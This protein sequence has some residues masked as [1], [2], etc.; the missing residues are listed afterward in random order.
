MHKFFADWVH[1]YLRVFQIINRQQKRFFLKFF[2]VSIFYLVLS[3]INALTPYLLGKANESLNSPQ[4]GLSPMF[5]VLGFGCVWTVSKLTVLLKGVMS[6]PI[7]VR[8]DAAIYRALFEHIVRLPRASQQKLDTGVVVQ[9]VKRSMMSFSGISSSVFWVIAPMLYELLLAFLVL[10]KIIS[11]EFAVVFVIMILMLFFAAY[12]IAEKSGVIHKSIYASD[13]RLFAHLTE[14]LNAL[15]DIKINSAYMREKGL[16]NANLADNIKVITQANFKSFWLMA[17]Q[18]LS[19]GAVLTFCI[20]YVAHGII[21][22]NN[23]AGSFLVTIGYIVEITAPFSLL[24][25]SLIELKKD[26]ESLN[27]AFH[28]LDMSI[29]KCVGKRERRTT[30]KDTFFDVRNLRLPTMIDKPITWGF[31]RSGMH[32]ITGPSGAGKT[33][34][35]NVMLG[36]QDFEEGSVEFCGHPVSQFGNSGIFENVAFVPQFP[37]IFSGTLRENMCYGTST[38]VDDSEL[39]E[40]AGQLDLFG[41]LV[42]N[43]GS[44]TTS[45]DSFLGVSGA[46]LS[47]GER[48]RIGIARA[49]VRRKNVVLLDEPTSAVD[50][51]LEAKIVHL[52]RSRAQLVVVVTHREAIMNM[53]DSVLDLGRLGFEKE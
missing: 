31:P 17:V 40:I 18:T 49:L 5:L 36:L 35:L 20:T 22:G 2:I 9:D 44:C 14:R 8:A 29:E 47:G 41:I 3:S 7:L 26:F 1:P 16:V 38:D 11:A 48:Q 53:A 12:N 30:N 32:V 50:A 43:E 51:L 25:S 15:T 21:A 52:L 28:Y 6:G 46:S 45:L 37:F 13:N 24:T 23:S 19:I 42:K 10:Y 27:C 4:G 34:L 33:T 39:H